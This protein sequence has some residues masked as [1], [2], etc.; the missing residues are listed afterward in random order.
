MIIECD[1]CSRKFRIDDDRIQPPGSKVRCSKCGYVF[2]VEVEVGVEE[3]DSEIELEFGGRN[4]FE[5]TNPIPEDSEKSYDADSIVNLINEGSLIDKGTSAEKTDDISNIIQG[6][7]EKGEKRTVRTDENSASEVN[8]RNEWDGTKSITIDEDEMISR[9]RSSIRPEQTADNFSSSFSSRST[10]KPRNNKTGGFLS[11]IVTF[12][13]TVFILLT[14]F[15]SGFYLLGEFDVV[16][17]EMYEGY[18]ERVLAHIPESLSFANTGSDLKIVNDSGTW[19][20]SRYGQVYMVSGKVFNSSDKPVNYIR[21]RSEFFSVDQKLF[22]QEF[23]AGNTLTE[24]EIRSMPVSFIEEK[25][26]RKS[27]DVNYSDIN[28]LAGTNFDIQPGES[29]P[30]YTVF[31]S[32]SRILGLNYRITVVDY[33]ISGSS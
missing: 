33:E 32:K 18:K 28:K 12:F 23:Y 11:G 20:N 24:S 2:Y 4:P 6:T 5:D 22:E 17:K 19:V 9:F 16:S 14:L 29:V 8:T 3:D 7:S 13:F 15:V 31:P 25:L 1:N 27:G 10:R 26:K 21:L 30:F